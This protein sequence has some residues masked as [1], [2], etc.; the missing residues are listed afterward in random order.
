MQFYV[1][2][3]HIKKNTRVLKCLLP[4]SRDRHSLIHLLTKRRHA[5]LS[6]VRVSLRSF[7]QLLHWCLPARPFHQV[8][9][10]LPFCPC[11]ELKTPRTVCPVRDTQTGWPGSWQ[12]NVVLSLELRPG[13]AGRPG[14]SA[15]CRFLFL[16]F[17]VFFSFSI[18]CN[19]L[20]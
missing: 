7:S 3:P 1:S 16:L 20:H 8:H 9:N 19:N 5:S 12:V 6:D 10:R 13:S 15:L 2:G 17:L 18:N 14:T 4:V 11:T